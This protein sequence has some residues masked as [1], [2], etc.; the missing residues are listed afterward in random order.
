MKEE[1]NILYSSLNIIKVT[2]IA[3]AWQFKAYIGGVVIQFIINEKNVCWTTV[4]VMYLPIG[5]LLWTW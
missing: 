4:I 2:S 5:R 3:T 1:F